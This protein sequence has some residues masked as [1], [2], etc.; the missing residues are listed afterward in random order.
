MAQFA[1]KNHCRLICATKERRSKP[2]KGYGLDFFP[3]MFEVLSCQRFC[4]I[5]DKSDV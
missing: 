2:R 4:C 1:L 5:G 3:T